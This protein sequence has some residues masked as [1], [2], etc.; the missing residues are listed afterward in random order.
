MGGNNMKNNEK[1]VQV[2][3]ETKDRSLKDFFSN[4]KNRELLNE[5]NVREG[6]E[7]L[8]DAQI[9]EF[10]SSSEEEM[11][12]VIGESFLRANGIREKDFVRFLGKRKLGKD[13]IYED[14][15]QLSLLMPL[16]VGESAFN[17]LGEVIGNLKNYMQWIKNG[18]EDDVRDA[19]ESIVEVNYTRT[20][21]EGESIFLQIG[22][23]GTF[24]IFVIIIILEIVFNFFFS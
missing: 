21:K 16:S 1:G 15:V 13:I 3:D 11:T 22:L 23:R 12:R 6:L 14:I 4:I 2:K 20:D 10:V 8:T 18:I 5:I 17:N 7:K 19:G 9:D 24:F